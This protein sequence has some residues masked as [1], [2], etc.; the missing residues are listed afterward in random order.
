MRKAGFFLLLTVCL[1]LAGGLLRAQ[2]NSAHPRLYLRAGEEKALLANIKTDDIWTRMH[3]AIVAEC[4]VIDTLPLCERKIVGP[5]MHAI[6]CEVL[7]RVLFL[8]YAWRLTGEERYAA[9]AE[10]EM[11]NAA[12]FEDWNP[13]HFLDTAEMSTA[14]AIGYDWLF[15]W[16]SPASKDSIRTALTLKGLDPAL[17]DV[18]GDRF[19]H[20]SNWGQVCNGGMGV[21]A[22][23]LLTEEPDKAGAILARS[24]EKILIP[25]N[26]TYPPEGCFP[27]GFGYWAFG[28]QYNILFLDALWKYFGRDS[29]QKYLDV[30]GFIE[31]GNYSQQLITPS[32][33]TFGYSDNS[34][35]IYLEPAVM[36]FNLIKPDPKMYYWQKPLFE[37]FDQTKSYVKTIKNRIIPFMVIWGAGTGDGPAVNLSN[38][39]M[40]EGNFY[41]GRG[42]ND[43]CVMRTGWSHDD[44]YLG[45][46]SGRGRNPH[47]HMDIGSF[48]YEYRGVRWSLDLGSDDYGK[49]QV[50]GIG[51]FDMWPTADR[52]N[53]LTKYNNFAHSTTYPEGVHQYVKAQ[54]YITDADA[55]TMTASSDIAAVYPKKKKSLVRTVRLTGPGVTVSDR[56]VTE[57]NKLDMVWNM[58]TE[59][60]KM[61][62]KGRIIILT[63]AGGERLELKVNSSTPFTAELVSA[64]P[65]NKFEDQNEGINFLRLHYGV[66]SWADFSFTV[67]LTPLDK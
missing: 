30:P 29:I 52:W 64:K 19:V 22:I 17:D 40:P 53:K 44:A 51:L 43:I 42:K 26:A 35:R 61:Q 27:E 10:K 39:A 21:A 38:P 8:S 31:S 34:T 3:E 66:P 25:M 56:F 63:A 36:W 65:G 2:E 46:K 14:L 23:A 20:T 49:V 33:Q 58:T 45:F 59:A 32:L 60:R 6:S 4:S 62:R 1:L 37:K 54:C 50:H 9:R 12:G 5:R 15:G 11:L 24:R 18:Y 55:A 28:T 57:D 41:L 7:R 47:G 48:Y 13:S 16:L 67:T